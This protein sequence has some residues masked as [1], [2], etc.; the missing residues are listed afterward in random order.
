M[1]AVVDCDNFYVEC[2]RVFAP[3]L[4]GRPVVVLSNNDG[5]VVSRSEEA[6]ALGVGMGVPL[7]QVR[8]VVDAHGVAAF[9]SNYALYGDMSRRVMETLATFTPEVEAYSIDEAFLRLDPRRAGKVLDHC[10]ALRERV[11]KWTGVPVSVGVG[12]TKTLAKAAVRLAKRDAK[13]S[14]H[15]LDGGPRTEEALLGLGVEEVWGIGRRR[16]RVLRAAG[17]ETALGLSR[18]DG[19]WLRRRLSVVTLRTA[20]ELRGVSCLP[21]EAC[22]PPKRSVTTSRTFARPVEALAEAQEAVACF[23]VKAAEKLRRARMAARVLVVFLATSRFEPEAF[24]EGSAV[25][26]LPVPTDLTPELIAYAK[27]ATAR[28]FREG[29]RYKKA[30]VMLL[31]LVRAKPSQEGLFDARDRERGRRVMRVLDHVNAVMGEGTLR[32]AAEGTRA[33]QAWRTRCEKRSPRYTTCWQELAM[34]KG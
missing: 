32:F 9:S 25:V 33:R 24:E 10:H 5:C 34:V 18:A 22:P 21:L 12:P 23:A 30:G 2:E 19:R 29:R 14:V 8:D 27:A 1:F 17:I 31:D 4:R 28:A 26:T 16:A 15:C 13:V 20:Y 11:R 3:A 6:K 7:F